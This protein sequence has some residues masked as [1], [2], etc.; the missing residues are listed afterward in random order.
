[1]RFPQLVRVSGVTEKFIWVG[2]IALVAA[3]IPL[4]LLKGFVDEL[5]IIKLSLVVIVGV[6]GV[7]LYL[8]QKKLRG[9]DEASDVP[10]PV[11]FRLA[12]CLLVSQFGWWGAMLIGFL[13]RHVQSE[14]N[15]PPAPWLWV[16]LLVAA[17]ALV[18]AVG[19]A[20][21]KRWGR[22]AERRAAAGG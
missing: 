14:I 18:W 13:H 4:V 10:R 19:E 17:I 16:G 5:M 15:W 7:P 22:S 8:L 20:V 2:W 1:M 12:L 9:H 21:L 3:G 11:I 6:N